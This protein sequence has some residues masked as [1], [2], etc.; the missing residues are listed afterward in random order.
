MT[1][2]ITTRTKETI[3]KMKFDKVYNEWI[4]NRPERSEWDEL[5]A[6]ER[7]HKNRNKDYQDL[8]EPEDQYGPGGKYDEFDIID[9]VKYYHGDPNHPD[10]RR[11]Y[12]PKKYV[13]REGQIFTGKD[14]RK[15]MRVKK[16]DGT[17][18]VRPYKG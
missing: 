17:L 4:G 1:L 16:K 8:G 13:Q 18:G 5:K 9:G 3:T 12:M 14:G 11:S 10:N 7:A 15:W 6:Q 2:L